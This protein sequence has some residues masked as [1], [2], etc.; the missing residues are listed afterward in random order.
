MLKHEIKCP[1]CGYSE[2][3]TSDEIKVLIE[4]MASKRTRNSSDS[5]VLVLQPNPLEYLMA[6]PCPECPSTVV[7]KITIDIDGNIIKVIE[8]E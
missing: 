1:Y 7:F 2:E 6:F 4:E 8:N 3:M 5:V